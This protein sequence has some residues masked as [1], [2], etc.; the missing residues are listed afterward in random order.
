MKNQKRRRDS[1]SGLKGVYFTKGSKWKVVMVV[2]G[3]K[4]YL[5]TFDH[6]GVAASVYA[7]SSLR[8]HGVFSPFF[9]GA[10]L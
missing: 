4:K 10:Q 1:K 8:Y 7:K 9:R 6:K 2:D 5:G 3:K